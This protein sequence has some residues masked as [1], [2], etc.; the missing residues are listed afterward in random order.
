MTYIL[1]INAFTDSISDRALE[2]LCRENPDLRF[3]TDTN[4]KQVEIYRLHKD[5]EILSNPSSLSGEDILPGL[6]V[7]LTNIF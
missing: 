7:D 5:R 1:N 4:G 3:E 2:Q 6:S